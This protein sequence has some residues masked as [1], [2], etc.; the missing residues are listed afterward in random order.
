VIR[1]IATAALA[2]LLSASAC[3]SARVRPAPFR[4][5]PDTVAAGDLRGPFSGRVVEEETGRPIAG[6]LVY[7]T[8]SVQEGYGLTAPGGFREHTTSTDADGR[9][10]IPAVSGPDDG[11]SRLT[12]FHLVVYKRGY[13]AYRSDHR[14]SDLGP[15]SDFTQMQQ[16][17]VLPR[18]R[19]ELSHAKH[20]RYIGGGAALQ[21]LTAWEAEPAARELLFGDAAGPMTTD[22]FGRRPA[23]G[24]SAAAV[25]AARLLRPKQIT[26]V[27]GFEGEFETGPLGDEPDTAQYSSFHLR[28][29]DRAESFDVALRLWKLDGPGAQERYGQLL[30]SLPTA[31]EHNEIAD[32]SLRAAEGQI[33]GVAFLDGKRSAV[34]LLTCGVAQCRN[35]ED[36]V[37]IARSVYERLQE[38]WPLGVSR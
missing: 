2:S 5:R 37:A 9:Y 29:L 12:D 16:E 25:V 34:V 3:T 1:A 18:W 19:S 31:V 14:F 27:T 6:A 13:V 28:A 24:D 35:T 4:A 38:T 32:R 30:G 36:A 15:R 22:P 33:R 21:S 23:P 17:I 7:A 8:W 11:S 10:R 26:D 20:L